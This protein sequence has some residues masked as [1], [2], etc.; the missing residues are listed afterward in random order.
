M[1]QRSLFPVVRDAFAK[2]YVYEADFLSTAEEAGL[3]EWIRTLPLAPAEYKEFQAKRRV[4]SYGGRYDFS[5]QRLTGAEPV[6][7][8]LE[9]L[10]QRVASWTG[11]PAPAFSH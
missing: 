11:R 9:P 10:R 1:A 6:P 2:G 4:V 7:P 5:A 8:F 3:V